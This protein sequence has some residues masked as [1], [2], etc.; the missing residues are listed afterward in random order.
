MKLWRPLLLILSLFSLQCKSTRNRNIIDLEAEPQSAEADGPLGWGTSC[1]ACL[2]TLATNPEAVSYKPQK[3]TPQQEFNE[4]HSWCERNWA[5]NG[6]EYLTFQPDM[7]EQC[8]SNPILMRWKKVSGKAVCV[9]EY[10]FFGGAEQCYSE[11]DIPDLGEIWND[12][13]SSLRLFGDVQV[14]YWENAQYQG[15]GRKT[16]S[17]WIPRLEDALEDHISSLRI[18]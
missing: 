7:Q 18:K 3:G 8:A 9:Y 2:C 14:E 5:C 17:S 4:K 10:S 15:N 12:R 11:G 6:V 13:I 1:A 16:T